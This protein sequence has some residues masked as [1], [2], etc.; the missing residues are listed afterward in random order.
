M[1]AQELDP[2]AARRGLVAAYNRALDEHRRQVADHAQA[3][4]RW[5]AEHDAWRREE[6][7]LV[8]AVT[9]RRSELEQ[10]VARREAG[11][12]APV[13][14]PPS[15][16][17]AAHTPEPVA[18]PASEPVAAALGWPALPARQPDPTTLTPPGAGT[19]WPCLLAA[20]GRS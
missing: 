4:E 13:A 3:V 5:Q 1:V 14:A 10:A 15:G 11:E 8:A 6:A 17:V 16:P 19:G 20:T 12:A 2:L 9:A 18:A 7:D